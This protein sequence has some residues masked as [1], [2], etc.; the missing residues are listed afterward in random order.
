MF[1]EGK[2]KGKEKPSSKRWF[3]IAKMLSTSLRVSVIKISTII[4]FSHENSFKRCQLQGNTSS[5]HHCGLEA[6]TIWLPP[7]E[8]SGIKPEI[9]L[10][11]WR[12]LGASQ[13]RLSQVRLERQRILGGGERRKA[14]QRESDISQGWFPSLQGG[15]R[16]GRMVASKGLAVSATL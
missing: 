7:L 8:L 6:Q 3:I 2:Q 5:P 12:K 11:P 16:I 13:D 4:N 10:A 14:Q 9:R 1:E 15:N